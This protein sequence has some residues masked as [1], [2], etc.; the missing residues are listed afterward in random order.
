MTQDLSCKNNSALFGHDAAEARWLADRK[1]GK[2]AHGWLITGPKGIGKA[3]LAS[4]I[5]RAMLAGQEGLDM[6]PEHPVFRRVTTGAHPDFLM[7]EPLFDEKKG[8]PKGEILA[9]QAREIPQFMSLTPAESSWR[10]VIVDSV[11]MLNE[12]AANAIL[13]V[14]E[15]PPPQALLLLVSHN[16]G[17]LLPTIRSRCAQLRLTPLNDSAFSQAMRH[18]HPDMEAGA[19]R[20]LEALSA[21]S[22]GMAS[23][24]EEQGALVLY[25]EMLEVCSTL[26]S[27]DPL[28]VHAFADSAAG[29]K[30]HARFRL[31]TELALCLFAR[32]SKAAAGGAVTPISG[33]EEQ[34]LALL[35]G[36]H[37]P[38]TWAVK[39]QQALEQ[40][41]LA[42]S[43]HLD[44]KQVIIVFFHSIATKDHFILGTAA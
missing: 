18:L 21:G 5:A 22:P 13:K 32:V 15:E 10:V 12:K 11:D 25:E 7:V 19:L 33:A 31:F 17:A 28:K 8:E 37:S 3:T 36:I 41:S 39:W 6:P 44:Y 26:P 29:M 9:E 20:A 27:L 40:F 38:A 42:Q 24:Y 16:P 14:L 34:A 30:S 35:S 2:L 1:S 4:R 43:R 23:A